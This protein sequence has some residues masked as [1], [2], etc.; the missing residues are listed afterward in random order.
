M[1]DWTFV[2]IEMSE[3]APNKGRKMMNFHIPIT[4]KMEKKK[5]YLEELV[6]LSKAFFV[7]SVNHIFYALNF[8]ERSSCFLMCAIFL[9]FS[10]LSQCI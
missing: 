8:N 5:E 3:H 4:S 7:A 10:K 1:D 2:C 6:S 9:W